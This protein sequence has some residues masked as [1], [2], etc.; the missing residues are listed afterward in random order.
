[1]IPQLNASIFKLDAHVL[2]LEIVHR[3]L[4]DKL[5]MSKF[6]IDLKPGVCQKGIR[7]IPKDMNCVSHKNGKLCARSF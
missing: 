2:H 5:V 6:V 4:K 7:C 1:M 3:S